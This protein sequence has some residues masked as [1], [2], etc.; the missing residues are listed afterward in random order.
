M[1][2]EHVTLDNGLQ[3]VAEI[4]PGA[5][6]AAVGIF[7]DAGS[8][9]EVASIAGVS[10]FLEHMAFKGTPSRSADDVN[11]ELDEMGSHSNA[12]TSEEQTIYHA[13]VLPVFLP[14]IT[15]LFCDL[16]RPSLRSEDFETEKKVII[17]EILMYDDQPPFGGHERLMAA[18]YGSHPL[19]QSV[20]G[21]VDSVTGLTPESMRKYFEERYSSDNI[22]IAAA[23]K[24]D[25]EPWL[26]AIK[27]ATADWKPSGRMRQITAVQPCLGREVMTKPQASQEY[28][29]QLSAAPGATDDDRIAAR[30]LATIFGDDTGSRLFWEFVDPG[31]AEF[32]GVGNYEFV[33]N[34]VAFTILCCEPEAMDSNLERL[35]ELQREIGS[36]NVTEDELERA[37]RKTMASLLLQ[38]ERPENRMF[39]VG[40]Q[41][42]IH[43]RYRT[44]RE[45]AERYRKVTLADLKRV[46]ET[47]RYDQNFTLL[48]GPREA[49]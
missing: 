47:Y 48:V 6:S 29:L 36:G 1:K 30:L 27:D 23:G 43:Q 5:H 41:W 8:R 3:V 19:G 32:A 33:G 17:E 18:Y 26:D 7:V 2:F 28:L 11:R 10:H 25:W 40:N 31:K 4:H 14:E 44:A 12:R 34:G 45:V 35:T 39:S 46:A 9:D 15:R 16:M 37:K 42:R 20:L 49:S 38:S 21:T 22:I 24:V 13:S